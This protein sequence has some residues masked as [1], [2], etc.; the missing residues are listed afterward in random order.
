MYLS[1]SAGHLAVIF[2]IRVVSLDTFSIEDHI[3]LTITTAEFIIGMFVNGYM[4]LVIYIDWIKKKKI[5]T[6][7]YILSNLAHSRICLLCVMTLNGTI[8]ALY[9][10]V[11]ENEKIKVVLNIF[12]TF[13]NYLHM[14]FA[15]CLNV[16]CLF[17]IANFFHRLFLWLKWRIERVFHWILLGSLAISM[18]ISLIQATLTNSDYEFLK[19][20]DI[21]ETSPNCSM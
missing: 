2:E 16:F 18:L 7:D 13:T 11:Y 9:P 10:V 14:W 17:K 5:S 12:W 19:I 1:C 3:F 4:G 20:G 8:L 21:K 6:T 15:T